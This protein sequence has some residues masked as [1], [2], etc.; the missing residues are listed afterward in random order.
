MNRKW[1][2]R[3]RP[4]LLVLPF[5]LIMTFIFLGGL[6]QAFV[7]SLGY[8]PTFG[9]DEVSL[10]HYRTVLTNARFI[11]SLQYTFY[12]A[13]ISSIL[14]VAIGVV[15]AFMIHH[16]KQGEKISYTLYRI[17]II[18]P[19]AVVMIV[20]IQVF[21]QTGIISRVLYGMGWIDGAL[22]FP[23][24]V[25]DRA[26]I[27]II[28]TYL[29]KQV[30]FVTLTVFA[31]LKNLDRKY[32]QIAQNLGASSWQTIRR[33]TLPLLTPSILS[34]FLITFAFA[35][36]AFEVPFILG[37]PARA[38]L[39]ILAYQDFTSPVLAGRP[40]AMAMSV[41]ISAL[42]LLLIGAYMGLLKLLGKR[43]LEEGGL[44]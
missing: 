32:T 25:N 29:Y 3:L 28:I 42:S 7:Q 4:Y 22:D 41:I 10:E 18:I 11:G 21:F 40:P 34:A 44:V 38:T 19:H 30:P 5:L 20:T 27:G 8:L 39:P 13:L 9:M 17:P 31:V 37:N 6:S 23:L 15:I 43:G 12:I 2:N 35:F 14:S 24:L 16:T 36:G 33:V 26:G 1:V